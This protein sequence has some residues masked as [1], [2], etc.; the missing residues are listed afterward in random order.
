AGVVPGAGVRVARR[1][2]D[3]GGGGARAG[4]GVERDVPPAGRASVAD[5]RRAPAPGGGGGAGPAGGG[6]APLR[7]PRAL[8]AAGGLGDPGGADGHRPG[9][10]LLPLLVSEVPAGGA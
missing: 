9:V 7:L 8:L 1:V 5:G 6:R 10:V 3:H 4:G 2:R